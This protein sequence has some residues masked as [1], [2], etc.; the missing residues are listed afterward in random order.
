MIKKEGLTES[1]KSLMIAANAV[2]KCGDVNEFYENAKSKNSTKYQ[3]LV[4]V[5]GQMQ[6]LTLMRDEKKNPENFSGFLLDTETREVSAYMFS[7]AVK[8]EDSD[9]RREMYYF[10]SKHECVKEDLNPN[11]LKAL[12]GKLCGVVDEK[13]TKGMDVLMTLVERECDNTVDAVM[14][15]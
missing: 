10:N 5:D 6:L 2:A 1:M 14:G 11:F 9:S 3:S 13:D 7:T 12:T 4:E 8:T 15:E